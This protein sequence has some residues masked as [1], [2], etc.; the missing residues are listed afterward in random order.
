MS[1]DIDTARKVAHLARIRVPED[2]L[3]ALASELSN[4]LT[5]M[6]QL[7]EVDVD[8]IEPMTSVTPMR[9]K[10]R[11]DVVTDGGYPEKVLKNAPDAREGFFAVPKV[12]E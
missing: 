6:E 7:G 12:V 5:F 11:E 1:I 2:N 10:R 9:L 8:G 4:I 3:P